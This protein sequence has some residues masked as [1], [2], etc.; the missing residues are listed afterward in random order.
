M[1]HKEI[2]SV[3]AARAFPLA[4]FCPKKGKIKEKGRGMPPGAGSGIWNLVVSSFGAPGEY[5]SA[6]FPMAPMT[7]RGSKSLDVEIEQSCC[8]GAKPGPKKHPAFHPFP[9]HQASDLP[10]VH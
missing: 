9:G 3:K 8:A 1:G 4:R 10:P 5:W 7:V 6:F 2:R